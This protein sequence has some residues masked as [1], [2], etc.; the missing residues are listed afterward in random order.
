MN[1][2]GKTYIIGAG[3]YEAVVNPLITEIAFPG[4]PV[5]MVKSNG[6]IGAFINAGLTPG[7]FIRVKHY[8]PVLPFKYNRFRACFRTGRIIT[9]P[10]QVDMINELQLA[11]CFFGALL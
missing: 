4:D 8:D 3:R 2:M 5:F 7:T 11:V 6:A 9:V 10:A 1:T